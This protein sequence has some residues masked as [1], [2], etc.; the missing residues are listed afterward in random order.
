MATYKKNQKQKHHTS[1][2]PRLTS[3]EV[4]ETCNQKKA[5]IKPET[6][7]ASIKNGEA[8][9]QEIVIKDPDIQQ[10]GIKPAS[11]DHVGTCK[12]V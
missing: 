2:E 4:A 6:L 5:P 8:A 1:E 3:V 9:Q 10:L 11:F 12:A 7:G